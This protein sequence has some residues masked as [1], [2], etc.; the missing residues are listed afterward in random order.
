MFPCFP[1]R[2]ALRIAALALLAG[3]AHPS[4]A[5]AQPCTDEAFEGADYVVCTV[6]AAS[7]SGLRIFWKDAEGMPVRTFSNLAKLIERS[8]HALVFA[9][10]GGMYQRDYTPVGLHIEH[11][12]QLRPADVTE[13]EGPPRTVPNFYKKPNGVFFIGEDGAGMLP[14]ETFLLEE[15]QARFATQSGPM[16]V[17]DNELH[18]ALIPGSADRTRRSGVGICG[19]GAVRFA[20]SNGAVNFHDFARLFRDRLECRNALFLDGGRG[21]GLHAPALRRSDWSWY[22]GYGP[23]IGLVAE[24]SPAR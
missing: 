17:I 22:G 21:V 13:I 18:P 5:R 3:L 16:L 1:L 12:E 8:G 10:N 15:P 4:A 19:D 7:A 24:G 2:P 14:T 23:M 20:V 9:V 6:E 11:G